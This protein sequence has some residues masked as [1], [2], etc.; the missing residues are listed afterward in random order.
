M[1]NGI[2]LFI[3][4]VIG[5]LII[6][7]ITKKYGKHDEPNT[8]D[9]ELNIE[10]INPDKSTPSS[11]QIIYIE[12]ATNGLGTAGFILSLLALILSWAPVVGWLIWFLGH[13]FSFIGLFRSPRG[14]AIAGYILSIID[15]LVLIFLVGT[16]ATLF[17]LAL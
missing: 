17:G 2:V 13:I 14:L 1:D 4:F 6:I 15:L 12:R 3:C 11:P 7:S 16:L 9:D 5:I 8:E 10:N